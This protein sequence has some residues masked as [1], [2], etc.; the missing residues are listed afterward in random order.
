MKNMEFPGVGVSLKGGGAGVCVV[1]GAPMWPQRHARLILA[2]QP[3]ARVVAGRA[4]PL[5]LSLSLYGA[6]I[7]MDLAVLA[8]VIGVV[9]YS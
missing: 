2:K 1:S 5:S 9:N 6:M 8:R 3:G 4:A 7:P